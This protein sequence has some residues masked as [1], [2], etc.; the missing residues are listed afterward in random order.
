MDDHKQSQDSSEF[1]VTDRR[2]FTTDGDPKST[3]PDGPDQD[4][5]PS[6]TRTEE[7]H[8]SQDSEQESPPGSGMDFSTFIISLATSAMAYMGEVPDPATG[9]RMQSLEGAQ[10]MIEILS[11]L[12]AKTK[13]NLSSEETQLLEEILYELRMK[14]LAKAKVIEL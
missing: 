13:G 7:P 4:S 6:A 8:P 1:K 14:Y 3:A 12:Q 11:M 9:Q 5:T 2:M 10:Q